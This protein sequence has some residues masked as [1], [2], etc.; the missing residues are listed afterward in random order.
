M[1]TP[2]KLSSCIPFPN[3]VITRLSNHSGDG[4]L[5]VCRHGARPPLPVGLHCRRA[6][7][8]RCHHL[9]GA[10]SLRPQ[11]IPQVTSLHTALLLSMRAFP[12]DFCSCLGRNRDRTWHSHTPKKKL[13]GYFHATY[14]DSNSKPHSLHREPI[15]EKMTTIGSQT[16]PRA[17]RLLFPVNEFPAMTEEAF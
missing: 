16:T 10:L 9:E 1:I 8:H 15:G 14:D 2:F 6:R 5:E 11:V 3:T 17:E 13:N 7:R 4:G 12:V